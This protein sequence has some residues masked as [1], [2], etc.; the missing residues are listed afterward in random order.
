MVRKCL[1][2]NK[3]K[4]FGEGCLVGRGLVDVMCEG[5]EEEC[6]ISV[7]YRKIGY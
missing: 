6:V 5:Y 3:S 7:V 1:G 2:V 4:E